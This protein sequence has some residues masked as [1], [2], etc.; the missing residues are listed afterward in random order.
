MPVRVQCPNPDCQ[1]SF[2]ILEGEAPRFRRCPQC[3]WELS[4]LGTPDPM[5][6]GSATFAG[7]A[8]GTTFAARYEIVR[9]LG[10]GGMGVVY[11]AKD[12]RLDRQVASELPYLWGDEDPEFLHRFYREA[13]QAA[14]LHHPNI[15][16][17][18]DVGEHAGQPFLVM[19]YIDGVP[20]SEHLRRR[21]GPME[22]RDAIRLVRKLA[23]VM[24]AAHQQ[25]IIHRDLKPANIML[26]LKVG[27]I[28][29]DFGLARAGGPGRLG[30]HAGGP[31]D[32]HADAHAAGA[33]P[34][35]G[36]QDGPAQRRLQRRGDPLRAVDGPAAVRGSSHEIYVKLLMSEPPALVAA[37][38]PGTGVRRSLPEG[39]GEGAQGPLRLDERVR[40]GA[41][42]LS[43]RGERQ[44]F[45]DLSR[46]EGGGPAPRRPQTSSFAP[47]TLAGVG[48]VTIL[49]AGFVLSRIPEHNTHDIGIHNPR[50]SGERPQSDSSFVNDR[51][52]LT[53]AVLD[54]QP[55]QLANLVPALKQYREEV[56][57]V[58]VEQFNASFSPGTS[59][60]AEEVHD[61]RVANAAA[62]LCY[63]GESERV[64]SLLGGGKGSRT[65]SYFLNTLASLPRPIE[66]E[67]ALD[68]ATAWALHFDGSPG[69]YVRTPLKYNGRSPLTIEAVFTARGRGTIVGDIQMAGVA[70]VINANSGLESMV[71]CGDSYKAVH[72]DRPIEFGRTYHV[73]TVF[74]PDRRQLRLYL[75]GSLQAKALDVE[76]DFKPSPYVITVGADLTRYRGHPG[77]A[78]DHRFHGD[79]KEVRISQSAA[80]TQISSHRGGLLG[81]SSLSCF[82][83]STRLTARWRT[84][85]PATA[86]TALL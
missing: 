48:G 38:Q 43:E 70:L 24:S 42:G 46:R 82:T 27:P 12:T 53:N 33:V 69:S 4:G 18:H 29:M 5:M 86:G 6:P 44:D 75:D 23:Q 9:H 50:R 28:V 30:T 76:G 47:L 68:E 84:I 45:E 81:R 64:R 41:E 79:I 20:L 67:K 60:E 22:A 74:D 1:A 72:A 51:Q 83:I 39:D 59:G 37:S 61:A 16:P 34:G 2:S 80:T 49:V 3:G 77:P 58:L 66:L 10:R 62:T 52:T 36:Q 85:P 65:R 35:Q 54:A 78:P 7:L 19:A 57:P 71:W 32:G 15:C 8:V 63:L 13:R 21:I 14:S 56:L 55:W 25:G 73:A 11:L 31:A 26:D 17:V 40:P